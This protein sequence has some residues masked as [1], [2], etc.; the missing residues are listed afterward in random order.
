MRVERLWLTDFRC[1]ESLELALTPGLT[2]VRGRNGQGKTS[3]LE[4]LGYLAT[5][6]SIRGVP[7][8][9]MVRV[10]SAG[11]VVRA[12][13]EREG[14]RL[15][16]EAELPVG[17][18]GARARVSVNRHRVARARDLLGA[19]RVS[20]FSPDDLELVKSGPA[21]RRR[22][23]DDTLV[24]LHPRHD[25]LQTGVDRILRQR[26]TLLR[27]AVGRI[28]PE[29]ATTLDVW[30]AQLGAAGEELGSARAGLVDRLAPVADSLYRSL[31]AVDAGATNGREA[32]GM[33]YEAPWRAVG[34]AEALA[35]SRGEDVRRA[36]TTVGPHR[37]ELSLSVSA[38]PAR[39]HGSQGEQRTLALALRLAAHQVVTE[40]VGEAPVLLL[41]DVFSE[42]DPER[43]RALVE[44]L[45]RGQA[46]L[47][48]AGPVPLA[49]APER[50]VR[51]EDG[52]V[53]E[54]G[55]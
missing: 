11:A 53:L 42:L 55:G 21:A 10:G 17:G 27:Q 39:T 31:A 30:D 38:L 22:Y 52:C 7:N 46:V 45:P 40:E 32:V 41:D 34:L 33:A 12:E 5:L 24:A 49:A 6:G 18:G 48:T 9:A 1:Y 26:N 3:L 25:A 14:R 37:D 15:L 4:A 29:V 23:L 19:L 54:E 16:I 8:E 2:V 47:T 50:V 36:V 51:I 43:S 44:H 28:T 35:A 20:V 13:G